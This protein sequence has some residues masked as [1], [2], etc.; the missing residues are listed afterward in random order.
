MKYLHVLATLSLTG[1]LV[2]LSG[3]EGTEASATKAAPPTPPEHV[4]T[5]PVPRTDG[6]WTER[7]ELLNTRASTGSPEIL[8]IGDS[9]T[10]AWEDPGKE[11]WNAAYANRGAINLGISGDRTQ[12]VLWRFDNGHLPDALSPKLA[13]VMIGTNNSGHDSS[14]EIADGVTAVVRQLWVELPETEILLL[15]IF[16]RG[17]DAEDRQRKV[18]EGANSL[19]AELPERFGDG[20]VHWLDIGPQFL[21]SDGTL[22]QEIMPDLLHLSPEGYRIWAQAIEP[23]VAKLL[24]DEP[25]SF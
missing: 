2:L 9:I 22:S 25:R 8:F 16:P 6:W 20:R 10:Q 24:G 13:V 3:C 5:L 21:G 1:S 15:A 23:V 14:V 11:F 17:A 19:L 7:H 12:H 18:N 4:A